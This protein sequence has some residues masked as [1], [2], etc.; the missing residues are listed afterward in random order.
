[1]AG[2]AG[3][4]DG[5]GRNSG[6]EM[7]QAD[8]MNAPLTALRRRAV[9]PQTLDAADSARAI[10]PGIACHVDPAARIGLHWSSPRG[11]LLDIRTAVA[12]PGGWLGLHVALPPLDLSRTAW[13]GFVTRTAAGAALAARACLRS[14]DGAGGFSDAFFDRHVLSQPGETDHVDMLAPVRRPD[15]PP[16][17]PW[18]EFILFLPPT[19]DVDWALHDLRLV[20]A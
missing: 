19:H 17:A 14:G 10:A 2:T 20:R 18:R 8:G 3:R 16:Q 12:T 9:G 15:L 4:N 1:M 5:A 11:R 7:A 6:A 13:F